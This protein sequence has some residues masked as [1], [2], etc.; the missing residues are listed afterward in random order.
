MYRDMLAC[1]IMA[2]G[3]QEKVS[4]DGVNTTLTRA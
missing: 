2:R 4:D 3:G 1:H